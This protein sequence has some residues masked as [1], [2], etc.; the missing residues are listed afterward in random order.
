[1]RVYQPLRLTPR[2]D[3]VFR[4]L[5]SGKTTAEIAADLV[6]A[7][8][9]A[10]EHVAR[11]YAKFDVHSRSELIARAVSLGILTLLYKGEVIPPCS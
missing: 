2:E 11:I 3:E 7:R 9:T 1:M 4:L 8:H 6:I 5:V 10:R